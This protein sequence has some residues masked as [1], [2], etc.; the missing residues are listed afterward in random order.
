MSE[1]QIEVRR[2]ASAEGLPLP[3]YQ[4]T[5][6]AGMDVCSASE[7][8]IVLEP[9]A[10]VNIPTGL[11]VSIPA[12]WELQIRPR[13]GLAA[14]HGV[15]LPNTPGT[16][17]SDY[18]GEIVVPLINLGSHPFTID[19]GMRVAQAVLSRVDRVRWKEVE[20]LS[21]S[22]RGESGLGHTGLK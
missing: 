14:S 19:R 22:Q 6:A 1:V 12:G 11:A 21:P 17:D 3:D 9:G 5:G 20:E 8:K 4:T 16:I 7:G 15:T 13:S 2:L 10:I 18:R